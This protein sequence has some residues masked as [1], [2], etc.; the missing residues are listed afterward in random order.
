MPMND[1]DTVV[2]HHGVSIAVK[3][4][5]GCGDIDF[6]L[7]LESADRAWQAYERQ[8][9]R[10]DACMVSFCEINDGF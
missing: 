10:S 7:L 9:V 8:V 3:W 5:V 2:I 6:M 1:G 4:H